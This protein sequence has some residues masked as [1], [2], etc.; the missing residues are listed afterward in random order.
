MNGTTQTEA[1]R[2]KLV[3]DF[4]A[5]VADTEELL[6]ATATQ[7][8]EKVTAVRARVEERLAVSKQQLAELERGIAEKTRA[9]ARATDDLVRQHPWQSVG[10]AAAT[11]FLIGLL[12]SRRS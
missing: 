6:R 5:V 7:T 8:G 9:A 4:R 1:A 12:T 10:I 2:E 3:K 11:G